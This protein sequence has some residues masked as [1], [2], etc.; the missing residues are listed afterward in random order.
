[1]KIKLLLAAVCMLT[2][3]T[4]FSSSKGTKLT[5]SA[6]FATVA[7]AGHTLVGSWCECGGPGCICDPGEP[8]GQSARPIS[9]ASPADR[10]PRAKPGRVSGLDLGAGAFLLG[11]TLFMWARFR[12]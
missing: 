5:N 10:N 6:P 2:L 9:D 3:P 8:R 12:A 1:M 4:L 7:L 11:L